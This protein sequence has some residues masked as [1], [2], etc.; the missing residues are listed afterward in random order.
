VRYATAELSPGLCQ[1]LAAALSPE[2][3]EAFY[4]AASLGLLFTDLLDFIYRDILT[5]REAANI[6]V[7]GCGEWH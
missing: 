5:Q 4:L 6:K 1:D 7:G 2:I 3:E